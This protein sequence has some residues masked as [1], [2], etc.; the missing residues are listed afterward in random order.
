M[1]WTVKLN[2]KPVFESDSLK[3]C[4]TYV[5]MNIERSDDN[6]VSISRISPE[7]LR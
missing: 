1:K 7:G 6:R 2:G 3:A 5:N 4:T